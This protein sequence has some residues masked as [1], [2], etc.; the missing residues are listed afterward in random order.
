MIRSVVGLD[1]TLIDP[2]VAV[3]RELRRRLYAA[4]LLSAEERDGG[5]VFWTSG[6]PEDVQPV[7]A[8]LWQRGA[9]VRRLPPHLS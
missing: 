3:A 5:E 2:A 4:N 8:Q 1:V 7:I 9:S 6:D